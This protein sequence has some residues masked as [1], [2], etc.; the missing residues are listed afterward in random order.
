M[1]RSKFGFLLFLLIGC[2]PKTMP[3]WDHG[4]MLDLH[5]HTRQVHGVGLLHIDK[6][7]EK[8]AISHSEWMNKHEILSHEENDKEPWDRVKIFGVPYTNVGENIAF[9]DNVGDTFDMWMKSA[10]HK[11]NILNKEYKF[12]GFGRSGNYWTAIFAGE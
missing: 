10:G 9:D 4:N 3:V 7:L 1:R 2:A 11:K 5:N 8:A 12:V 6:R